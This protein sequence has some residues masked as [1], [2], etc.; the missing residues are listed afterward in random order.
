MS[1]VAICLLACLVGAEETETSWQTTETRLEEF[2]DS[3][4]ELN[5]I[6]RILHSLGDLKKKSKEGVDAYFERIQKI[7]MRRA[8]GLVLLHMEYEEALTTLYELE[9]DLEFYIWELS[10]EHEGFAANQQ[11]RLERKDEVKK[12][13]VELMNEEIAVRKMLY[14]AA[15]L[16]LDRLKEKPK[17]TWREQQ[18]VAEYEDDVQTCEP[19]KKAIVPGLLDFQQKYAGYS[20][21]ELRGRL[22]RLEVQAH[23]ARFEYQH[24]EYELSSEDSENVSAILGERYGSIFRELRGVVK[25]SQ[26]LE[27]HAAEVAI[28]AQET[29]DNLRELRTTR[30]L[31]QRRK[32]LMQFVAGED[33]RMEALRIIAGLPE[34]AASAEEAEDQET[35]E[36]WDSLM[37]GEE[38]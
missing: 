26:E 21:P 25:Q 1:T 31:I 34:Q 20:I 18:R 32:K 5:E 30:G 11:K 19:A 28:L 3:R 38:E 33:Q 8:Q 27:K 36:V 14:E 2:S 16:E 13:S 35:E 24:L 12:Q 37:G 4:S 23:A 9:A 17:L 15:K 7:H 6:C 29:R 10:N 22:R